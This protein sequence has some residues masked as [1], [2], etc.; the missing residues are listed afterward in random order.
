ML[1]ICQRHN[2]HIQE[3]KQTPNRFNPKKYTQIH[4]VIKV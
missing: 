4:V 3:T 2:I 1:Q